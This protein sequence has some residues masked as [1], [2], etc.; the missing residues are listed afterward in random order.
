MKK[1]LILLFVISSASS[2]AQI[3]APNGIFTGCKPASFTLIGPA[4]Y[5]RY[6]WSNGATTQKIEYIMDGTTGAILDTA[7]VGLTCYDAN[8][9]AYVQQPVVV[10]S[11]KEPE[12]L[13]CFND[14]YNY[15]LNDSIKSELVLT[16]GNDV[17]QYVFTFI[18]TD[19][20]GHGSNPIARYVSNT[21]WCKLSN[22]APML[23][24]GKFY[25][26]TVHARINNVNYCKGNYSVIGIGIN[27]HGHGNGNGNGGHG[28]G[29]GENDDHGNDLIISSN[30]IEIS[31]Y[32]NPSYK[33]CH[34]VV[35]SD[36]KSPMEISIYNIAGQLIYR[37]EFESLPVN[38]EVSNYLSNPGTYKMVITQN[39]KIKTSSIERL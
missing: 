37:Q 3:T 12:L 11:I 31:S 7:T 35:D 25:Y 8:N 5:A 27:M 22:V 29:Y 4:G 6:E 2:F 24:T 23:K 33:D 15:S 30:P 10:R 17:P 14:K 16:Y 28:N 19:A 20:K 32:P 38:E 13:S 21:R 18:Q 34:I 9:T 36:D 26:V 39:G 1:L